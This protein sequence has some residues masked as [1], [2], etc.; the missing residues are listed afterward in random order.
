VETV[1]TPKPNHLP[2]ETSERVLVIKNGAR[3]LTSR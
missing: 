2:S 1:Q 3:S